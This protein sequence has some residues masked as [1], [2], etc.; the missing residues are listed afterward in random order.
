[1]TSGCSTCYTS[2]VDVVRAESAE[3]FLRLTKAAMLPVR[4][5]RALLPVSLFVE[6]QW[7]GGHAMKMRYSVGWIDEADRSEHF[8]VYSDS[9]VADP[10]GLLRYDGTLL[11]RLRAEGA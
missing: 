11:C 2:S 10:S 8:V 9:A 6:G 3:E 4:V 5:Q 1:M 7:K